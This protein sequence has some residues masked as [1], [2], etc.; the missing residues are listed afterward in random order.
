VQRRDEAKTTTM[1]GLDELRLPRV[2]AKGTPQLLD[3]RRQR[4]VADIGAPPDRLEETFLGHDGSGL[5]HEKAEDGG[6]FGCEVDLA[7]IVPELS[8]FDVEAI[9][10]K[11]N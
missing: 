9:G 8:R 1:S 3:A 4:I 7:C 10:A 6:R 11:T 5:R 2:V